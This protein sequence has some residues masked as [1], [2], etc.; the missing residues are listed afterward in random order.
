MKTISLTMSLLITAL[1]LLSSCGQGTKVQDDQKFYTSGIAA[2]ELGDMDKA[3]ADFTTSI[4]ANPNRREV[5]HRR[6]LAYRS[7]ER[8]EEAKADLDAAIRLDPRFLGAIIA[9]GDY[10]LMLG[11]YQAALDDFT[12]A[13]PLS[14]FHAESYAGKAK[15]LAYLGDDAASQEALEEAVDLGYLRPRIE[16]DISEIKSN[17]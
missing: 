11:D 16:S 15:A 4:T 7:L 14:P 10:N 17:R 12:T 8:H 6:A 3:I 9:R 1:I 5:Y 2:I 13:I